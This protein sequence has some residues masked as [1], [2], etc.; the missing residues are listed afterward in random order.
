M[1]RLGLEIRGSG[2]LQQIA[3][4]DIGAGD[5]FLDIAQNQR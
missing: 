3:Q 4:D 1:L 2:Q 5:G